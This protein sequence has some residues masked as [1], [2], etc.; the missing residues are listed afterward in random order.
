M[1]RALGTGDNTPLVRSL[2]ADHAPPVQLGG[3]LVGAA[4]AD[5]IAWGARRVV[6]G[7]RGWNGLEDLARA[8][9]ADRLGLAL[10]VRDA[11]AW[12]PDGTPVDAPGRLLAAA[13]EAGVRTVVYR[14]LARDGALLGPA[15]DDVPALVHAGA[16]VIVAGGVASPD[17]L[18]RLRDQGVAGVIV[19]RALL[20]GR[21]TI[22]EALA[23]CG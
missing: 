16:D 3:A 5:A 9:G 21:F 7:G 10:D 20:E 8:H 4:V 11:M 19:G 12:M 17:D 13:I 1:D 6:V 14:D 15:L 23:C 2:L 18:R 22:A